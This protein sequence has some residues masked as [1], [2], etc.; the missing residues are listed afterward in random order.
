MQAQKEEQERDNLR[1]TWNGLQEFDPASTDPTVQA[2]VARAGQL[3][4][5]LPKK[6]R[7]TADWELTPVGN[8]TVLHNRRTN[9]IKEATLG[10]Q[11]LS[12]VK[13][14]ELTAND[15]PDTL[16]GL[17]DEKQIADEARASVEPTTRDRRIK[18]EILSGYYTSREPGPDGKPVE[19]KHSFANPDG[20]P[21]M[22][23]IWG[24]IARGYVKPSD[25]WENVTE[26]DDQRLAE[27]RKQVSDRY[28]SDRRLVDDFR[29]RVTRNRPNA[30]AVPTSVANVVDRFNQIR[31]MPGKERTRA[32]KT[33]YDTLPYLD[34]R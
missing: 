16:F 24:G 1:Q 28:S 32:L 6:T 4:V 8:R 22:D 17:P 33:F 2:M 34:I 19:V 27:A 30:S 11:P 20:S 7:D 31:K 25:V 3:G 10:G 23:V 9:E 26:K 21:N 13:E 18:P 29:L 5:F 14:K 12:P 15:L